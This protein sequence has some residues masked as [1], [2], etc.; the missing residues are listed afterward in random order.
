MTTASASINGYVYNDTN[1]SGVF[2]PG[3]TGL[4]SV[5]LQLFTDPNGDGNPSDG[6]LVQETTTDV[7][8]Y[9]ELLNLNAGHY[10]IVESLLPGYVGSAPPNNRQ[11]VNITNLTAYTNENFFQYVPV[12]SVYSTISGTVWNDANGNGTN[13]AGEVGIA[14][15][16]IDLVQDANSNG[17]ADAGEPIAV[18]VLT[19][20]NGHYSFAGITPGHYVIRE[21]DSF[22]Y[23]SIAEFAGRPNDN[24]IS[25]FSTNGIVSS[26]IITSTTAKS[27]TA[28]ADTNSTIYGVPGDDQSAD[29]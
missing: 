15:V 13:D 6:S 27:P 24:Q 23:Y 7:N 21:I 11:G 29:Q 3:D 19:D 2:V 12:P 16:E 14:N 28:I 8:G 1:Q 22:G 26:R 4:S 10:V 18:S 9:Y 5:T 17:V 25:F 20:T